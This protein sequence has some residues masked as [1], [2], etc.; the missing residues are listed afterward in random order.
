MWIFKQNEKEGIR[1]LK[2]IDE[3]LLL[4]IDCTRLD[5]EVER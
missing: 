1:H 2:V 5:G 4:Q 3:I